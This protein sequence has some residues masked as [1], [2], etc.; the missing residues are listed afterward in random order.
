[1]YLDEVNKLT[2]LILD[3]YPE[4]S[5]KSEKIKKDYKKRWSEYYIVA[6]TLLKCYDNLEKDPFDIFDQ[7]LLQYSIARAQSQSCEK[8]KLYTIYI[9]ALDS[10]SLLKNKIL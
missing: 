9:N 8:K 6:K 1:M 3:K 2:E 4:P 5:L 7:E 10:I